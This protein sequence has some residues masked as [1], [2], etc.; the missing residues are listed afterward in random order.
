[1]SSKDPGEKETQEVTSRR[2]AAVEIR[3]WKLQNR[4]SRFGPG[5]LFVNGTKEEAAKSCGG[6]V[7]GV[8]QGQQGRSR[9]PVPVGSVRQVILTFPSLIAP[10]GGVGTMLQNKQ[11][12]K[13]I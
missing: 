8:E 12:N 11:R 2:A 3:R 9:E 5:W 7:Q 10:I 6:D 1:M 13:I 4:S